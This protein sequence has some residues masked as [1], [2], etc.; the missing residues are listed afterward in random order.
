[1]WY[2][3]FYIDFLKGIYPA[4]LSRYTKNSFFLSSCENDHQQVA[5]W[6][7]CINNQSMDKYKIGKKP[8]YYQNVEEIK[9]QYIKH[10]YFKPYTG[11]GYLRAI[12]EDQFFSIKKMKK[13][14][15]E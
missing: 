15:L 13:I 2:Q 3:D 11:P 7:W 1:M 6:L 5:Q 9:I 4:E 14:Y 12:R 10:R 8:R